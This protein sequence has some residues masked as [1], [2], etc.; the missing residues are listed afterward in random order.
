[1]RRVCGAK[2]TR[3]TPV[4]LLLTDEESVQCDGKWRQQSAEAVVAACARR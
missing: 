2:V 1:M 3:L 4:E